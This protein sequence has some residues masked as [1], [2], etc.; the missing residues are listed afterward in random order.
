MSLQDT[1]DSQIDHENSDAATR[2]A[3]S[4]NA[5]QSNNV[6]IHMDANNDKA[7]AVEAESKEEPRVAA[8]HAPAV[9]ALCSFA[10]HPA[11]CVLP[12]DCISRRSQR[13][14]ERVAGRVAEG[15]LFASLT[16]IRKVASESE[17]KGDRGVGRGSRADGAYSE[18]HGS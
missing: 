12:Y 4:Y 18:P 8:A 17:R 11:A 13:Y 16:R 7:A 2:S 1:D 15:P 6:T 9:A 3:F 14:S 5:G 10:F